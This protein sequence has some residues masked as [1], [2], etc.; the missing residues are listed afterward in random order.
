MEHH[1]IETNP[2]ALDQI[3]SNEFRLAVQKIVSNL[4]EK[5]RHI[6]VHIIYKHVPC[7]DYAKLTGRPIGTF[8]G[9]LFR[10][11]EMLIKKH[12]ELKEMIT[13]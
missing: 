7:A 3:I 12:H 1:F 8:K 13:A 4:K 9:H 6:V 5:D 11:R 10:I 2:N